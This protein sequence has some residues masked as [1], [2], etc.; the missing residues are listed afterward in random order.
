MV[1]IGQGDKMPL[2][3]PACRRKPHEVITSIWMI[4]K[5]GHPFFRGF[6]VE[7]ELRGIEEESKGV[8]LLNVIAFVGKKILPE[9]S[10]AP[11]L[12]EDYDITI[13]ESVTASSV[14]D[15]LRHPH[16]PHRINCYP[17]L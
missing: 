9:Q 10:V 4:P 16:R 2:V 3:D 12:I 1:G 5:S 11:R 8:E 14:N 7:E 6:N 17:V 15:R 13:R